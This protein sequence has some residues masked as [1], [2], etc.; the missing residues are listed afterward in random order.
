[1]VTSRTIALLAVGLLVVPCFA[2]PCSAQGKQSSA[3]LAINAGSATDVTGAGAS[4]I[5]VAPSLTRSS[6]L[7]SSTIGASATK[8]ANDAWTAGISLGV[9]GRASNRAITPV[10]DIAAAAATTSYDFSY[11]SA[12]VIPSLEA[13]IGAAKLFGGARLGA[14][15]TSSALRPPTGT[16]PIG[17]LPGGD[18]TTSNLARS[19]IAGASIAAVASRGEVTTLGYRGETGIV[20]GRRQTDHGVS[21]SIAGAKVVMAATIGR[22]M[23]SAEATTHGTAS[24]GLAVSPQLML[25]FAAGSYP[26]NPMLGTA[27]GRFVNAGMSMRVGRRAASLPTPA[28]VSTPAAGLTRVSIRASDAKRVELGGDFNKWQVVPATRADNGV[29]YVDLSLP[30]GEYRY[31]FRI[32]GKEWRVPEGVAAADDEFGGRTAWLTVAKTGKRS[33]SNVSR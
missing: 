8:F 4:A 29:W 3:S 20:A 21:G 12:E 26:S 11:G 5:T 27:A 24:L 18:Q 14:A 32:D 31:A 13:T 28:G 7:S 15:G 10:I 2:S 16:A 9:N 23:T 19:I 22:R 1:M 6:L 30:P 33:A 25:Q 17:T